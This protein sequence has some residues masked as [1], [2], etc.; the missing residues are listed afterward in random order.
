M[1]LVVQLLSSVQLLAAPWTAAHQASLSLST[2]QSLLKVVSVESVMPCNHPILLSFPSQKA[3]LSL[4]EPREEQADLV[5]T[6]LG[7]Q[8]IFTCSLEIGRELDIRAFPILIG[9]GEG[10]ESKLQFCHLLCDLW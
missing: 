8:D 5:R 9:V 6:D 4:L 2:F 1:L 3:P 7:R 10:F